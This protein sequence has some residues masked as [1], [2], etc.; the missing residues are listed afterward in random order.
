MSPKDNYDLKPCPFCEGAASPYYS[1][2]LEY[3][4]FSCVL[5][6]AEG[7]AVFLDKKRSP[8]TDLWRLSADKW[9]ERYVDATE[10]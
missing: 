4:A 3:I 1:D 9:N 10:K 6:F 7:P 8:D 2:D 5:C